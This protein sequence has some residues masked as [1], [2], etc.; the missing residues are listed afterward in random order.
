MTLHDNIVA[1]LAFYPDTVLV[2]VPAGQL[3]AALPEPAGVTMQEHAEY[4]TEFQD[5]TGTVLAR[6]VW[7]DG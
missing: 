3:A 2:L 6:A 7:T 1:Y 4:Y 5:A